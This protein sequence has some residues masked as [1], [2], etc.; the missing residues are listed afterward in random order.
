VGKAKQVSFTNHKGE[1]HQMADEK[2]SRGELKLLHQPYSQRKQIVVVDDT[3]RA[4][5]A[6][7]KAG[8]G[9]LVGAAGLGVAAVA[10]SVGL[11]VVAVPAGGYAAWNW[12]KSGKR[13]DK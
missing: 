6:I 11:A 7:A 4:R 12:R 1:M 13:R 9:G 5:K 3:S 8:K 2:H 10:G